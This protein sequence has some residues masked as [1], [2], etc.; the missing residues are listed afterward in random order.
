[1]RVHVRNQGAEVEFEDSDAFTHDEE[2]AA[3]AAELPKWDR[4]IASRP[5]HGLSPI[6][7]SD[8]DEDFDDFDPSTFVTRTYQ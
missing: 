2:L 6:L 7:D 3:M 1:M 8:D 4:V 5:M